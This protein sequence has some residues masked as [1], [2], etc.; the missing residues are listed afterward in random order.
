MFTC[1][2]VCNTLGQCHCDVGFSPPDCLQPGPGG[3][4]HSNP[5]STYLLCKCCTNTLWNFYKKW[6]RS[7]HFSYEVIYLWLLR[8]G[9][10]IW[11]I[12]DRFAACAKTE[13]IMVVVVMM[14]MMMVRWSS[15]KALCWDVTVTCPVA[16]SYINAAD[17]ESG[18]A[19]ELAATRKEEKYADLDDRYIFEPIAIETLGVLTHQLV[20]SCRISVRKFPRVQ[21][22]PEKRAFCSKDAR[23]SCNVSMPYCFMTVY[24]PMTAPT[25]YSYPSLYFL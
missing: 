4:P 24:Q 12:F 13:M 8:S 11:R 23:C 6:F 5:A 25:E 7:K 10:L 9:L 16:E 21:G 19:A 1:V 18:A 3:S 2:Q 14:T 20:I 22:K 15:G 17:R